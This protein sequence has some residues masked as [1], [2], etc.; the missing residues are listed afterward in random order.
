M[1]CFDAPFPFSA[2]RALEPS[3]QVRFGDRYEFVKTCEERSFTRA[4]RRCGISQPSLTAA[5]MRLEQALGSALFGRKPAVRLTVLGHAVHPYLQRIVENVDLARNT[6]K[7]L[8]N[9]RQADQGAGLT[10]CDQ[11][12]SSSRGDRGP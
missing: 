7:A 1:R 11:E 6:A 10:I 4:A 12:A 5:I 8:E 9:V 3:F 2:H